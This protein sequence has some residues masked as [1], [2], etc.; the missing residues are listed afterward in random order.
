MG[1]SLALIVSVALI[2]AGCASGASTATTAPAATV[3]DA[4]A[5]TMT[6]QVTSTAFAGGKMIPAKY[7]CDGQGI[8]VPLSWSDPLPN[9]RSFALIVDD[10]DA[11]GRTFVHWVLYNLPVNARRLSEGISTAATLTDG[12]RNGKNSAGQSGY[13]GPCPPSG[14]HRYY[15]KLYAL[16]TMLQLAPGATKDQLLA[17]MK[18]HIVAQGELMGTYSRS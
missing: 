13:I 2:T 7:T 14:T 8:S 16:D 5:Q 17:A 1:K 12:S 4:G 10:P 6:L 9:T 18:D 15:F 11:P 3:T